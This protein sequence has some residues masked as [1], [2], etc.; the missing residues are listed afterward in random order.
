VVSDLEYN[1]RNNK[2]R[3]ESECPQHPKPTDCACKIGYNNTMVAYKLDNALVTENPTSEER[4]ASSSNDDK[5]SPNEEDVH[6]G[7]ASAGRTTMKH[8]AS[9][10]LPEGGQRPIVAKHPL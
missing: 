5:A 4:R 7:K 8:S 10:H 6:C 9:K 2:R 1:K 3:K